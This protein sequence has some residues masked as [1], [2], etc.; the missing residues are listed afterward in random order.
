MA[1]RRGDLEA[2]SRP[3]ALFSATIVR[4]DHRS[5]DGGAGDSDV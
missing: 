3:P 5:E 2:V 4:I 1:K